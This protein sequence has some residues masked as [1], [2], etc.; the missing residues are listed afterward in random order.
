MSSFNR[1]NN[2]VDGAYKSYYQEGKKAVKIEVQ[3]TAD[4]KV[5]VHLD[6]IHNRRLKQLRNTNKSLVT[7]EEFLQHTPADMQ[8]IIEIN[9]YDDKDFAYRVIHFAEENYSKEVKYAKFIYASKDKKTCKHIQCMNRPVFHVHD[10]VD[11]I[12]PYYKQIGITKDMLISGPCDIFKTYQGVYVTDVTDEDKHL[13]YLYPWV[14]GWVWGPN[15]EPLP[16]P[17][18]PVVT[19]NSPVY[20]PPPP[21]PLEYP[22]PPPLPRSPSLFDPVP[23]PPPLPKILFGQFEPN[24]MFDFDKIRGKEYEFH[25]DLDVRGTFKIE[26]K[27]IDSLYNYQPTT[28]KGELWHQVSDIYWGQG[29]HSLLYYNGSSRLIVVHGELNDLSS[30][31][32]EFNV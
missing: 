25:L 23:P 1:I 30:I 6:D 31:I 3:I 15:P 21:L 32:L 29:Y 17:L 22:P 18:T 4:N 7:L 20:P 26:D 8:V 5:V 19:P 2:T 9:R 11:T 14:K 27:W 28:Y 10:T 13:T 12:D 16:L 24:D